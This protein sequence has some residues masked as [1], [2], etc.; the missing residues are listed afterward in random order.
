MPGYPQSYMSQQQMAMYYGQMQQMQQM[1]QMSQ[2]VMPMS[3]GAYP[4]YSMQMPPST[5]Q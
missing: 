5:S 4:Q 3:G 1:Q 2:G